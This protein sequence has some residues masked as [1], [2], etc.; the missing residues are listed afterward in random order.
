MPSLVNTEPSV[1]EIWVAD[2]GFT[3]KQ[4]PILILADLQS[5]DARALIVVVPLTS[6]IRGLRG[7]VD[8]GKPRWLQK[9]SDVNVQGIASIDR[10][11]LH[12]RLGRLAP[13]QLRSVHAAIRDLL[14]L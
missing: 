11:V 10:S 4:R 14:V 2:F 13:E 1:G 7:D 8:I 9:H 12:R 3:A 6:Q 5:E